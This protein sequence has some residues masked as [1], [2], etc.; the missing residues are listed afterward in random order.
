MAHLRASDL[1]ALQRRDLDTFVQVMLAR[2]WQP[3]GTF[4]ILFEQGWAV[5]YQA[6]FSLRR[7][8][9]SLIVRYICGSGDTTVNLTLH[10]ATDNQMLALRSERPDPVSIHQLIGHAEELPSQGVRRV[11]EAIAASALPITLNV[12]DTYLPLDAARIRRLYSR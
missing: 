7:T 9:T 11:L 3:S 2:G 10:D 6:E 8:R 12:R 4:G 5:P 1:S